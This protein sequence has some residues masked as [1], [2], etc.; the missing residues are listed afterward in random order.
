MD[1]T[2]ETQYS[3]CSEDDWE[4]TADAGRF[5]LPIQD[6]VVSD[7]TVQID[8]NDIFDRVIALHAPP[9]KTVAPKTAKELIAKANPVVSAVAAKTAGKK[10]KKAKGPSL[11]RNHDGD[12]DDQYHDYYDT[13]YDDGDY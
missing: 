2:I 1:E 10:K 11:T 13:K 12:Y 8:T 5:K 6:A 7:D 3:W 9:K 4:K